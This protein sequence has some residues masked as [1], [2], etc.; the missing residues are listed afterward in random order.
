MKFKFF[1]CLILINLVCSKSLLNQISKEYRNEMDDFAAE[2]KLSLLKQLFS[3]KNNAPSDEFEEE[4]DLEN[5]YDTDNNLQ[6]NEHLAS[7]RKYDGFLESANNKIKNAKLVI[8]NKR[9]FQIQTYYDA[10]IQ[11]DG[12]ILLIPKDVNK[13]HY[14]IG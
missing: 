3:G 6:S 5:N 8:K 9:S 11:K 12:S 14:F 4:E 7:K 13:N 1:I 10:I 2:N